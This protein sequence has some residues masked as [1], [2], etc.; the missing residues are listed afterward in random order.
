MQYG[1]SEKFSE[2]EK[3]VLAAAGVVLDALEK[4]IVV[5]RFVRSRCFKVS[6]LFHICTSVRFGI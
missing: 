2:G 1:L 6:A 5:D 3:M 4:N